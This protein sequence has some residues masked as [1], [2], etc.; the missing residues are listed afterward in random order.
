MRIA[1]FSD[2]FRP[3]LG[4]IQDSVECLARGLAARGHEVDLYVPQYSRREYER[5]GVPEGEPD[6]G[7]RIEIHRIASLPYRGPNLQ[8]RLV[9]PSPVSISLMK[10]RRPDIIHSHTVFGLG[11]QALAAAKFWEVPLIATHHMAQK[12]FATYVSANMLRGFVRYLRWYFNQCDFVSAP[13]KHVFDELGAISA[14]HEVIW[15]AIDLDLFAPAN[16]IDDE[17]RRPTMIYAGKLVVEKRVDLLIR[18]LADIRRTVPDVTLVIAGH[19]DQQPTLQLQARR[20]GVADNVQFVGTLNK[21]D[22][23]AK[24][25]KSDIFVSMSNSEVQSISQMQA[26]ACGLPV[27]CA[28][29]KEPPQAMQSPEFGV[30]PIEPEA[31]DRFSASVTHLLSHPDERRDLASRAVETIAS[32]SISAIAKS[33]EDRYADVAGHLA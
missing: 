26:M 32:C 5:A 13:A 7:P 21:S 24:F 29:P 25:R 2:H 19:G 12:V 28:S 16:A 33:W 22:L 8:S 30:V 27:V 18:S 15:N 20:L 14:P 3:E 6:L 9:L 4:G 10:R 17:A 11:L 31:E 23:A 1:L